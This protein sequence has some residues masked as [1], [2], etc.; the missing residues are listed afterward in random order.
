MSNVHSNSYSIPSKDYF[1][2][3]FLASGDF[4]LICICKQ[5]GIDQDPQNVDPDL[6]PNH[7]TL[8]VFLKELF[9][10]FKKFQNTHHT[11]SNVPNSNSRVHQHYCINKSVAFQL[12]NPVISPNRYNVEKTPFRLLKQ[13]IRQSENSVHM[14]FELKR[15]K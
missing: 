12:V 9:E 2:N 5:F 7:L 8:I 13:L 3:S 4:C 6:D 15:V 14:D 1:I 10:N 11:K